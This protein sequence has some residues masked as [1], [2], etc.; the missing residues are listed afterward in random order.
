M[1]ALVA[2]R[3]RFDAGEWPLTEANWSLDR[4]IATDGSGSLATVRDP[5]E[6]TLEQLLVVAR[7]PIP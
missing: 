4:K 2:G 6:L 5:D 7:T 3:L 1:T